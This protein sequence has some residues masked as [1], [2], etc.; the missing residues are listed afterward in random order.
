LKEFAKVEEDLGA[1]ETDSTCR[2]HALDG[3]A[4]FQQRDKDVQEAID[5]EDA[6]RITDLKDF[7]KTS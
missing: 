7:A 6:D 3:E 2:S 4:K 5:L 1:G